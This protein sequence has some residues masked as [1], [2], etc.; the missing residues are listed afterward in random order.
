[1]AILTQLSLA[2]E[3]MKTIFPGNMNYK[4]FKSEADQIIKVWE[5]FGKALKKNKPL[6]Y[7]PTLSP[8]AKRYLK[9][10][11]KSVAF[12]LMDL[13]KKAQTH[14]IIP[15]KTEAEKI[16]LE[17]YKLRTEG[18]ILYFENTED[19]QTKA[20]IKLVK[21]TKNMILGEEENS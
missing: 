13:R 10:Y 12:S 16:E 11:S 3:F 7:N 6:K 20:F 18:F 2:E 8:E 19:E 17:R 15:V 5:G 4:L 21:D 9:R 1:M 14:T